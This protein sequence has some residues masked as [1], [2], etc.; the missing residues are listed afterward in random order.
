VKELSKANQDLKVEV[1]TIK[2]TTKKTKNKKQ[3]PQMD[4]NLEVENLGKRSGITNRIQGKKRENL[5]CRRYWR[6]D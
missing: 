6:G 3:K 4:T 2:T 1:E 5:R